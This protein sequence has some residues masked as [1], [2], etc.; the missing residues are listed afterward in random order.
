ML[1]YRTMEIREY[2]R[3]KISFPQIKER[4]ES[5]LCLKTSEAIFTRNNDEFLKCINS[6]DFDVNERFDTSYNSSEN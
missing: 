3:S 1:D 4:E 6:K 2:D 5:E